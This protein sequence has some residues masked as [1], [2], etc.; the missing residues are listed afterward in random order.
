MRLGIDFGTTRT[1]VATVDRG[2]Y[3]VVSF[4]A[5]DGSAHEWFPSLIAVRGDE[6]FYG[7]EAWERQ[8]E[9]DWTIVRSIK[10]LLEESG[11]RTRI[12][13]GDQTIPLLQLLIEM[14][15]AIRS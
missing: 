8:K 7:W 9:P 2:N 10:R 11:P 14:A 15:R 13:I 6:R 5:P 3:P 4:E 12:Q 1:V